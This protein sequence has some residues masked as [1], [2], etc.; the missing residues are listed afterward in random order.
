MPPS[1]GLGQ[2]SAR[3]ARAHRQARDAAPRR[4]RA[5][6]PSTRRHATAES[7][8]TPSSPMPTMDSHRCGVVFV[9][10]YGNSEMLMRILILG[11]TS[12]A[13]ELARR[14]GGDPRFS[15]TTVACRPHGCAASASGCN[16]LRRLR[17][18]RRPCAM[19]ERRTASRPSS[20]RRTRS[21]RASR[22]TPLRR[23]HRTRAARS[24]S[25]GRLAEAGRRHLDQRADAKEAGTA[26]G[27]GAAARVSDDRTAGDCGLRAR[28]STT[29]WSAR[30]SR[31]S[32]RAAARAR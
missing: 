3:P 27:D 21:R 10:R 6:P 7:P 28:R 16:A 12:E 17:R 5:R 11:G 1:I 8:S 13:S 15:T 24:R 22:P 20:T 2:A 23:P 29:T 18:R 4:R 30:S 9:A 19:G 26:L 32:G 25:C 14:L 31:P